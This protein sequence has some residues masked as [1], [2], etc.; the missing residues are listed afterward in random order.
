MSRGRAVRSVPSS[1]FVLASL[2]VMG[3]VTVLLRWLPFAFVRALKGSSLFQ[4]LGVTMPVGVMVALVV[5]TVFA[6]M[7]IGAQNVGDPGGMWAAPLALLATFVLHLW[8]RSAVLAV[9]AG[10]GVYMVLVNVV[11]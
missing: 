6:R 3:A 5:Y 1:G 9:F 4:F 7:G 11:V 8:R 10:T 2:L